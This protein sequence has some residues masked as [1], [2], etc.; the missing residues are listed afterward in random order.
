M[1]GNSAD[2]DLELQ[3]AIVQLKDRTD[4]DAELSGSSD[5]TDSYANRYFRAD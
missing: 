4:Q 3:F 5:E 1:A 2:Q